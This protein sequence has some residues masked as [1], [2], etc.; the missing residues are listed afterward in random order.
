L[1]RRRWHST[2]IATPQPAQQNHVIASR[3]AERFQPS[4]DERATPQFRKQCGIRFNAH[5][6][7]AF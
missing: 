3:G 5:D 4:W 7:S 2:V 6:G 1:S